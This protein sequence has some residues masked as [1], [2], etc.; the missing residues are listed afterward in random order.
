M[1]HPMMQGLRTVSIVCEGKGDASAGRFADA[2]CSSAAGILSETLGVPVTRV[3]DHQLREAVARLTPGLVWIRI[4]LT[5]DQRRATAETRWGAA[6][7]KAGVPPVER[8]EPI[9]LVVQDAR[10]TPAMAQ[11]F[12]RTILAGTPFIE[13]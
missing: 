4:A 3:D 2:V 11:E 12:A 1:Q 5:V 6:M 7:P 8:A 13:R 9:G 10:L